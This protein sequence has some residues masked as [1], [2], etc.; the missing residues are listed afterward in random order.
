M[1]ELPTPLTDAIALGKWP[2]GRRLPGSLLVKAAPFMSTMDFEL[3][4]LGEIQGSVQS[5]VADLE[6]LA[7]FAKSTVGACTF[8][9]YLGRNANGPDDLPWLDVEQAVVLGGGA[10]VGDDTWIAL[11]YR[12]SSREPRV[13]ISDFLHFGPEGRR[14]APSHIDWVELARGVPEL[15]GMIEGHAA[16]PHAKAPSEPGD[17]TDI[18]RPSVLRRILSALKRHWV[19]E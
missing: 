3:L 19:R 12:L 16:A 9:V 1:H 14:T 8:H 5:Q 2:T 15:L 6:T 4:T 10:D 13:V 18:V 7:S 17:N 11:D